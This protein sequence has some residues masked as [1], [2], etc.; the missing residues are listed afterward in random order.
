M[1]K[2]H[3]ILFL[4]HYLN[5]EETLCGKILF[6]TKE[7]TSNSEVTLKCFKM[8]AVSCNQDKTMNWWMINQSSG[9]EMN[10]SINGVAL[11][12]QATNGLN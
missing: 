4:N 8:V 9:F 11:F 5:C 12:S 10:L 2:L 7:T 1:V 3:N 6:Y